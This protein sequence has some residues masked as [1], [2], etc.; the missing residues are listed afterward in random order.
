MSQKLYEHVQHPHQPANVNAQRAAEQASG[1]FNTR[2]AVL[3]TRNVGS[4]PTAYGFV[5]LALIGLLAI[6]GV[7]PP[8]VALLVAWTSQ[9]LIQL[10]LLPIIM[11]GQ[12]VQARHSELLADETFQA[13][14]H[15]LHDSDQLVQHLAAQDAYALECGDHL[16]RLDALLQQQQ[17]LLLFLLEH[18]GIEARFTTDNR[19]PVVRI[20]NHRV[21]INE[22]TLR[23]GLIAAGHKAETIAMLDLPDLLRLEEKRPHH[24]EEAD[25]ETLDQP[26]PREHRGMVSRSHPGADSAD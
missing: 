22:D 21:S 1:G 15:T 9:T 13:A 7:I 14:E 10:C 8:L 19:L 6:L 26:G 18:F 25:H 16:K 17:E 23:V 5:F 24:H 2:L 12:N 11:V 3:L 20:D 4:M